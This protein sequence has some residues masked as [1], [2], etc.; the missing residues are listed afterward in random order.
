MLVEIKGY[1]CRVQYSWQD[2]ASYTFTTYVPKDPDSVVIREYTIE[3]DIDTDNQYI[4]ERIAKLQ[5]EKAT[6]LAEG[7]MA[8]KRVEE[9]IGA[10]A[11]LCDSRSEKEKQMSMDLDMQEV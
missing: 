3:V 9:K 1:I 8:V 11:C 2:E 10:L 4:P 7:Q 5:A 6:I